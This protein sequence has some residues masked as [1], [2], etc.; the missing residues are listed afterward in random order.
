MSVLPH[1]VRF[2]SSTSYRKLPPEIVEKAKICL[3][4]TLC[5][6]ALGQLCPATAI[7]K[8]AFAAPLVTDE[9]WATVWFEGPKT[10][11]VNAIF[12]NATASSAADLDDG[13]DL[14]RGHA[15]A[16]VIPAVLS[17]GECRDLATKRLLAAIAVGYEVMFLASDSLLPYGKNRYPVDHGSG[18]MGAIGVAGA[19]SNLLG[20]AE[21]QIGESLRIAQ[22]FMPGGTNDYAVER[23]S[24]SKENINWGAVTGYG[25]VRLAQN[26]YSGQ[27]SVFEKTP[28]T[29]G[30]LNSLSGFAGLAT[31]YLKTY[32][33][34]RFTHWPIEALRDIR[35]KH[36]FPTECVA[37]IS[38]HTFKSA[39]AL[40]LTKPM[41]LEG[42]QYS[43]PL[44]LAIVLKHGDLN[45]PELRMK[46][47]GDPEI[48]ALAG[49]VV[50]KWDKKFEKK[51]DEGLGCR[52]EVRL[53]DGAVFSRVSRSLEG[54][55][56]HPFDF[57]KTS[58]KFLQNCSELLGEAR[59]LKIIEHVRHIERRSVHR[60]MELLRG[61]VRG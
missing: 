18:S 30:S 45:A 49:R 11:V 47:R 41:G 22:A 35:K 43:I 29:K 9:P 42:V 4:D 24:M 39:T 53:K 37:E 20:L 13:L 32:A 56:R 8:R 19:L 36:Q 15:G 3:L 61:K 58:E 1:I 55:H 21:D 33:S 23:G 17:T 51:Y 7:A 46:W 27:S 34:C 38:V 10:P 31:T 25:A 14:N 16:L 28:I 60:L 2:V 48:P 59:C 50:L 40:S 52:L 26:G 5:A 6:A 44:C 12:I 57:P 54:D